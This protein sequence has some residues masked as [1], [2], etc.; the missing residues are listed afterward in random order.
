MANANVVGH[1]GIRAAFQVLV[2]QGLTAY[3][4]MTAGAWQYIDAQGILQGAYETLMAAGRALFGGSL[5]DRF[6]VTAELGG[7]GG[8]QPLAGAAI[9]VVEADPRR[10]ERRLREGY[11]QRRCDSLDEALRLCLDA[12][13]R[14][15]ALSVGLVDNAATVGS[16]QYFR[17]NPR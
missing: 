12:K 15:V 4:G 3:A 2:D 11:L 9:L 16:P 17:E 6:V 5:A 10:V 1:W 14:G 13:E 7:M 8:A